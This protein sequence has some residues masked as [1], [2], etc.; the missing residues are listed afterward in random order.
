MS[1][2]LL[3]IPEAAA[4]L[5]LSR[6]Q[7]YELIREGAIRSVKIGSRGTR[8]PT[9]EI[10][11][12]ISAMLAAADKRPKPKRKRAATNRGAG[13]E[14]Y[15]PNDPRWHMTLTDEE[16]A[17]FDAAMAPPA[18]PLSDLRD[19]LHG[20]LEKLVWAVECV[21]SDDPDDAISADTYDTI[22]EDARAAL[23]AAGELSVALR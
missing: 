3:K 19:L 9:T 13:P 20:A 12:L 6:S 1:V 10:G 15:D 5:N 7:L 17:A 21:A 2:K 8:I 22:V 11:R 23:V 18:D 4:E 14:P 16:A